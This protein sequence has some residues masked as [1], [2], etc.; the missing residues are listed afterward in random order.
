MTLGIYSDE[1]NKEKILSRE[2][3]ECLYPQLATSA[4]ARQRLVLSNLKLA[5]KVAHRFRRSYPQ[6]EFQDLVGEANLGLMIAIEKFDHSKGFRFS[7]YAEHWIR[8]R[9]SQFCAENSSVVRIPAGSMSKIQKIKALS[10]THNIREI[11]L[12]LNLPIATVKECLAVQMNDLSI[13]ELI[14][15]DTDSNSVN[16]EDI[17]QA[18]VDK[19]EDRFNQFSDKEILQALRAK[20]ESLSTMERTCVYT[21]CGLG[22][23]LNSKELAESFNKTPGAMRETKRRAIE[24]LRQVH[25]G[26][27]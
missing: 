5:T 2:E 26:N 27:L 14:H 8:Q 15:G 24:K 11:S 9:V 17:Y 10:A 7:T 19:Q 21:L 12:A 25:T 23:P 3:E 18:L 22:A 16:Q 1:M 20:C 13:S 6:F 4:E